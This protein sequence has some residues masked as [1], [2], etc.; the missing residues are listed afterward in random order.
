MK[1]H[2]MFRVRA[3]ALLASLALS[4]TATHPALAQED[5][6]DGEDLTLIVPFERDGGTDEWARFYAPLI[7]KLY[8]GNPD[9]DVENEA[10]PN[11][12]LDAANEFANDNHTD[13]LTMLA[14]S[15]SNHLPFIMRDQRVEYNYGDWEVLLVSPAGGVVYAS[16][17]L[18]ASYLEV[19]SLKGKSLRYIAQSPVGLDIIP[20]LALELLG[21]RPKAVYGARTRA[22]GIEAFEDDEVLIDFQTTPAYLEHVAPLVS[23]GDAI[24]LFSLGVLGRNGQL[25]RDPSFPDIPHFGETYRRVHGRNPT[26]EKFEI[27]KTLLAAG[28]SAQKMLFVQKGVDASILEAHREGLRAIMAS[29]D[30]NPSGVIGRYPQH[31]DAQARRLKDLALNVDRKMRDRI[32]YWLVTDALPRWTAAEE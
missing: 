21:V 10:G 15:A 3:V 19:D 14:V 1:K 17:D 11:G 5:A 4:L 26:G 25:Q 29:S 12:A 18:A 30:F 16:P 23:D 6:F 20:L 27:W 32:G 7:E 28:F 22:D 9:V 31:V 13:G 8:P 24:P 2:Q